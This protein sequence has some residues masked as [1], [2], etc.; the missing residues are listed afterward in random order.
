MTEGVTVTKATSITKTFY[1]CSENEIK[2]GKNMT[3]Q[4]RS[5]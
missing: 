4:T 3:Q 2:K 1:E 5:S